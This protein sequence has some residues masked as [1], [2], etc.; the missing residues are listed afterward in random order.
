MHRGER[1][2]PAAEAA[3]TFCNGSFLARHKN[4]L[5]LQPPPYN[6]PP[7]PDSRGARSGEQRLVPR[8]PSTAPRNRKRCYIFNRYA[9]SGKQQHESGRLLPSIQHPP[10]HMQQLIILAAGQPP[11]AAVFLSRSTSARKRSG[12]K[13]PRQPF[14]QSCHACCERRATV[15]PAPSFRPPDGSTG[16]AFF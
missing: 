2:R 10:A 14:P 3:G 15:T 9:Q 12:H 1:P 8:T 11:E 16:C 4:P 13:L 7:A 5:P 6:K